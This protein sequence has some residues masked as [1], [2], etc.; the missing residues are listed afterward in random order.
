MQSLFDPIE[1]LKIPEGPEQKPGR[2]AKFRLKIAALVVGI[3]ALGAGGFFGYTVLF[4]KKLIERPIPMTP[5]RLLTELSEARDD[6]D[7]QTRDIYARIQQFNN[8][9]DTLGRKGVSF[10]QV[11]LQGMSAEEQQALD[12]LVRQEKDPS[13]QGILSQVVEDIKK[14]RDLQ[15]RVAELEAKLP[16]EGV[17]V[18]PGDS[19]PK[20]AREYLMKSHNIPESR[21]KELVA[22]LNI[23]EG[24]LEKG[25]RVHFFYDPAKNFFGSWV[26]QGDAKRTPLAVMRAREMKLIGER[27]E[28][29][30]RANDLDEKRIELEEILANLKTEIAA[31]EARKVS[32]ETNVEKLESEKNTALK[33]VETTTAELER[34]RNSMFYEVDLEERLRARGVLKTFNKVDA[35]G[36]VKFESS[37]DLRN[38]KSITFT[39]S[40]FG[41]SQIYWV[42]VV[43][44]FLQKGRDYDL[45]MTED[46]SAEVTVLD[47]KA[48]RGQKV[49]FVVETKN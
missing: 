30:A 37:I 34:Q 3:A 2:G 9:M 44:A 24:H 32:L 5:D 46:G 25:W 12:D 22:R 39:P 27:D 4:P 23:M 18:K 14:I 45:K 13:Y 38:G 31:L 33:Q 11:F 6:I 21:A 26:A 7:S 35:I 29:I 40:Q 36:N 48:L 17:E 43:P 10:S 41:V 16:G 19:H 1:D 20:L 47:E 28:A 8:R 49:L 15:T 42:R